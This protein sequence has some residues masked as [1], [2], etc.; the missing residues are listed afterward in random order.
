MDFKPKL[1]KREGEGHFIIIKEKIHQDVSVMNI[2]EKWKGTNICLKKLGNLNYTSNPYINTGQLQHRTLINGKIIRQK[3]NREITDI[4][5]V[6]THM[7]LTDIYRTFHLNA[8]E[9]TLFLI[10]HGT[11]SKTDPKEKLNR[12]K[13]LKE[14]PISNQTMG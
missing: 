6:M 13:N 11:F 14:A 12:D 10:L 2:Y 8:K 3:L 1:I 4:I 7:D 9:Y 5:E